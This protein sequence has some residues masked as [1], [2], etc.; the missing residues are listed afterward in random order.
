MANGLEAG[1]V[2]IN[3][4]GTL[5]N[6]V[7]FGGFKQSGWGKEGGRDALMEYTRVKNVLVDLS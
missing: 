1:V 4:Y 3:N 6:N 5:P 2:W 7:P